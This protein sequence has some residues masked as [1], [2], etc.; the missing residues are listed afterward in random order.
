[1]QLLVEIVTI[2]WLVR[3]CICLSLPSLLLSH[4]STGLLVE[5]L[6]SRLVVDVSDRCDAIPLQIEIKVTIGRSLKAAVDQVADARC[7]G[8]KQWPM[9]QRLGETQRWC[10]A[11]AAFIQPVAIGAMADG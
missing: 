10:C 1:M 5:L 3:C 6:S 2:V 7:Q 9:K 11:P 8:K 4:L